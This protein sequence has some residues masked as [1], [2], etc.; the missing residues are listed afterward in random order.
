MKNAPLKADVKNEKLSIEIGIETLAFAF[1]IGEDNNP[2]NEQKCCYVQAYAV[3][4]AYLFAKDICKEINC[5][6]EDGSTPLTRFLD[7]MANEAV[8]QGSEGI[9]E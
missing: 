4:N 6:A 7:T 5:E 2:Y 1:E 9:C 3:K 8:E